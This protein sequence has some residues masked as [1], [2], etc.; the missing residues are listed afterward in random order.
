M[1]RFN[2]ITTFLALLALFSACTV[3]ALPPSAYP[4]YFDLFELDSPV[5]DATYK[6]GQQ[7]YVHAINKGGKESKIYKKNPDVRLHLRTNIRYPDVNKI[8]AE[9]VPYRTLVDKGFY[10]EV[11]EEYI[12]TIPN[13]RYRVRVGFEYRYVDSSLFYLKKD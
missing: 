6:V 7:V 9:K 2:A 13:I 10:F 5:E 11:K 8:I 3:L 1:K 4:R 12:S